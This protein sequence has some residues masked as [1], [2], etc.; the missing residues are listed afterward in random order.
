[1]E[2]TKLDVWKEAAEGGEG[3]GLHG[4]E[5]LPLGVACMAFATLTIRG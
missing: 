3:E 4:G 5:A 2:G 1:M